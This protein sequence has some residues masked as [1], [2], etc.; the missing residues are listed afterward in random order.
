MHLNFDN[1]FSLLSTLFEVNLMHST[2]ELQTQLANQIKD[3][4]GVLSEVILKFQINM[5]QINL[6]DTESLPSDRYVCIACLLIHILL[7][8]SFI[9]LFHKT[10]C[11]AY[12]L[13]SS[14]GY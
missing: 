12:H 2:D 11:M 3:P 7:K 6:C 1:R 13:G 8:E 9:V 4:L 10:L 5:E 14:A